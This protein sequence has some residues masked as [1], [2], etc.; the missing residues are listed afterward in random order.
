LFL[1][2]IF[3]YKFFHLIFLFWMQKIFYPSFFF[4]FDAKIFI[5]AFF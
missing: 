4:V 1:D 3:F 2:A 5:R